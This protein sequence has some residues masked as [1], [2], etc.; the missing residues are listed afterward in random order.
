MEKTLGY[1]AAYHYQ[2]KLDYDA[3]KAKGGKFIITKAGEG[4]L[5]Y[6]AYHYV[7]SAKD[8]GMITGTYWYYRQTITYG[9]KETWCEPKK[10]AQ[11][12]YSATDGN[13]DLPPVLDIEWAGNSYFR[14]NDILTCLKEIE[15]LFGRKPIIYT[16]KYIWE[17]GVKSPSWSTNYDLWIAQYRNES[18]LELPAPFEKWKIWQFSEATM[19]N[20][21]VIDHNWFNGAEQQL[22]DY[23]DGATVNP[24]P[25]PTNKVQVVCDWLRLRPTP[26]YEQGKTLVGEKGQVFEKAG[27]P[28]YELATEITWLPVFVPLPYLDNNGNPSSTIM[29]L[30]YN[31]KYVSNV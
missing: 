21:K 9:G 7:Q 10:Q 15:R 3:L 20:G 18:D 5:D 29:Y 22:S 12:Y 19:V 30:S 8:A 14:A 17:D 13:F 26:K 6:N 11:I 31:P 28:V 27:E 1:D 25:E 16:G 24:T 2:G 23:A 4:W